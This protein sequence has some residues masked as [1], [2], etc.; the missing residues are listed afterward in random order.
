MEWKMKNGWH[1]K[2]SQRRFHMK[3]HKLQLKGSKK[4]NI[5]LSALGS[6]WFTL[7]AFHLTFPSIYLDR[8]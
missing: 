1:Y 5:S 6:T 4:N 7:H 8:L 3:A 2:V